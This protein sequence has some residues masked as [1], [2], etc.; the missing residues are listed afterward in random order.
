MASANALYNAIKD[1]MSLTTIEL[2]QIREIA[3]S[4]NAEKNEARE[5]KKIAKLQDKDYICGL[6]IENSRKKQEEEEN[7]EL[8]LKIRTVR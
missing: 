2:N 5:T 6:K 1:Q 3:K 4:L 7:G 8:Y